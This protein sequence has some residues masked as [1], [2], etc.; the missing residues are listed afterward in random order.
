MNLYVIKAENWKIDGGASFGVVPKTIWGKFI[1]SDENNLINSCS[2]CLLIKDNSKLILIDTGMGNKQSEKFYG[3]LHLFEDNNL[4]N[5]FSK[6]G[7]SFD[8]VS[9]VIFTHL[10]YDH[11]GGGVK[12]NKDKTETQLVFKNATYWCSKAQ[13]DWA[14]NP[15]AREKA[16]Y[17]K[18]NF[19]P[20]MEKK[21]LKF[22]ND[23]VNFKSNIYLKIYNGH[24]QGQ[25][26]PM[27]RYKGKI[28]VFVSDFI[29]SVAHIPLPYIP[30]YDIQPL[31]SLKEKEDFLNKAADKGFIL[32]FEHD[33]YNEC[34]TVKHTEK[35]VRVKDIFTLKQYF[36]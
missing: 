19:L 32:F 22:I 34:C 29:P 21:H 11:C 5:A 35:G 27:I 8:D 28:I 14:V 6:N 4:E 24:T 15:N 33:Y 9:D 12:Y 30:S 25:I 3:Y 23:E 31:I 16:S 36:D 1:P 13:W 20:V 17:F 7:F 10:H 26:I 2:R 18:E